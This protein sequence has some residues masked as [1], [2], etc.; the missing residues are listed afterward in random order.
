MNR[1][2]PSS[3]AAPP[4]PAAVPLHPILAEIQPMLRAGRIAEAAARC[5]QAIAGGAEDP[6]LLLNT[7]HLQLHLGRN[8]EAFD[9]CER[10]LARQPD[11]ID[12][13]F[14]R[15]LAAMRINRYE[16]ALLS[17]QT[18]LKRKPDYVEALTNLSAVYF[19]LG[20]I[21][22]ALE[23]LRK[24]NRLKSDLVPI[25]QNL[26][27]I[28]NYDETVPLAE[29]MELHR[30]AGKQIARGA[31]ARPTAY[32]NNTPDPDRPLRIGYLSGDFFNHPASH[33][34]EPVLRLHDRSRFEL[35]AYSL[36]GWSDTL[37]QAFRSM[38]PNWRDVALVDDAGLFRMIQEDRIDIL[39][40]LSGH[41]ARNR[42]MVVARKP[43]PVSINWIG[44]LN[45]MGLVAVDHAILDPHLLSPAAEAAFVEAPLK[46]PDT[47]YC[48]TPLIAG[49]EPAEAPWQRN[50]HITFGCFNNPAK[51]SAASLKAWAEILKRVPDSQLLFKY[52][53]YSV[54]M[55]QARVLEALAAHGVGADRVRFEGFSPLGSFLDTFGSIDVAL[56]SFPYSGVTTSMHTLYMGVPLVTLEGDTPMQRFGRT[57]LT[58]VGR[59]DW[60]ARTPEEYVA[61]AE[62][63]VAEVRANPGL[64]RDIQRRMV[65]SP[66]MQHDRF[67]RDLEAAYRHAWSLWCGR[68][69]R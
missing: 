45:S 62:A 35:F 69:A 64:R 1:R 27:S 22:E 59:T 55:V 5:E 67:V 44:Y 13:H 54:P 25:W 52:K 30:R 9:L 29:L 58:A 18:V 16:E 7:V 53:T 68:H 36:I 50:G 48:Y 41:T 32:P 42:A 66:M 40:D 46:L 11:H 61:I 19:G 8:Q 31:G 14:N 63:I 12:A 28:T 60:I 17:F 10:I 2:S 65:V 34:I 47:A 37:T 38:V 23:P 6:L 24:A 56:D 26:L 3:A 4:K 33:Y 39:V 21:R 57:A 43:A 51:L 49:R 20:F 15:G